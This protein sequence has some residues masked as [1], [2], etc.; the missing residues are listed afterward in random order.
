MS[1]EFVILVIFSITSSSSGLKERCTVIG[2]ENSHCQSQQKCHV[3]IIITDQNP[4][5]LNR[6]SLFF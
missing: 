4:K 3:F 1:I 2:S 6:N 5:S